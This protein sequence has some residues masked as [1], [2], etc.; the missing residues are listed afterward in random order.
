MPL[1]KTGENVLY[2]DA[3]LCVQIVHY[4]DNLFR[5]RIY[6]VGQIFYFL[7]PVLC[8]P[9]FPHTYVVHPSQR[10]NKGK[11]TAG[12]VTGIFGICAVAD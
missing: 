2:R 1:S 6:D 4:Q 7:C 9:V 8:R 11:D 12:S 5:I 3:G 10:L